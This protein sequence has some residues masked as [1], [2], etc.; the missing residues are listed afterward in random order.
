MLLV[1]NEWKNLEQFHTS[2][3]M[4]SSCALASVTSSALS[5]RIVNIHASVFSMSPPNA[6]AFTNVNKNFAASALQI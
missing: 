3:E 6:K 4:K 2:A 1:Q 5:V